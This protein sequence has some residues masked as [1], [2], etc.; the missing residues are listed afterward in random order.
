MNSTPPQSAPSRLVTPV[1]S[2]I[3]LQPINSSNIPKGPGCQGPLRRNHQLDSGTLNR[4]KAG[5]SSTSQP[6]PAVAAPPPRRVPAN[7]REQVSRPIAGRSSSTDTP[8]SRRPEGVFKAPSWPRA[9]R[10]TPVPVA[11]STA[12]K[13]RVVAVESPK[14][15]CSGHQASSGV[16]ADSNTVRSTAAGR[17]PNKPPRTSRPT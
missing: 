13:S 11:L 1:T 9:R 17:E 5:P 3:Q 14:A 6:D 12:T 2:P 4:A 16:S 15:C 8:T 7:S 10:V